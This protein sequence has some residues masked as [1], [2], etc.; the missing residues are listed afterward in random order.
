MKIADFFA[1]DL[2]PSLFKTA[3]EKKPSKAG[4]IAKTVGSGL[5]GMG[6]GYLSGAGATHLADKAFGPIPSSALMG[7]VPV[8]GAGAG[9]AYSL[10]KAH[11]QEEMRR[12]LE[13]TD[14]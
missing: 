7:A 13:G 8:L 11:E 10:Y 3:E 4:R 12:A 9:L 2:A 6:L 1:A 14:D 5:A